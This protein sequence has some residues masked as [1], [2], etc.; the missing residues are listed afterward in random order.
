MRRRC[1]LRLPPFPPIRGI[2]ATD[3][4]PCCSCV[5]VQVVPLPGEQAP[6]TSSGTSRTHQTQVRTQIGPRPVGPPTG[7]RQGGYPYAPVREPPSP[8]VSN[9]FASSQAD[10]RATRLV[11][12]E[13]SLSR[14]AAVLCFPNGLCTGQH[15]ESAGF[16]SLLLHIS[17]TARPPF[18]ELA[19]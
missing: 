15:Q 9:W 16:S 1:F 2:H 12:W 6:V 10:Q 14:I 17:L 18:G 8:R 5:A 3:V 7:P 4:L 19:T 11:S 13:S